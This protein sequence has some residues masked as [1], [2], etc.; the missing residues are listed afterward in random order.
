M[1]PGTRRDSLSRTLRAAQVEGLL[2]PGTFVE[3]LDALVSP[4]LIDPDQLIGDLTLRGPSEPLGRAR[5]RVA[6][7][8]DR[9]VAGLRERTSTG[10]RPAE[11]LLALDWVGGVEHLLIGRSSVCDVQLQNTDVSRLH[12]RLIFRDGAWI[13]QDLRS[14][15][16]TTLNGRPVVRGRLRPGD[17]IGF[18]GRGFLID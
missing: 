2:S 6:E 7:L 14:R 8:R 17:R 5:A 13:V 4:G 12:A 10:P 9:T 3:R 15:N 11:P 16:G 1:Q 18:A